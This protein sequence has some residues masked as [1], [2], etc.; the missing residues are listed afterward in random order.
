MI[1][2]LSVVCSDFVED[3]MS[4][5]MT[6]NWFLA[7]L[8]VLLNACANPYLSEETKS[9]G[10]LSND[11]VLLHASAG[12]LAVADGR[13]LT[14]NDAAFHSKLDMIQSA[15]TSVDAMYYIYSD[16]LSSS[17]LTQALIDAAVRGVRVRL[18]VD[19]ATTYNQL[20][21]FSMMEKY[22]NEGKGSL[23]VRLF[24]R[25][26]RAIVQD[27][28]Y[29]TL[30]CGEALPK[31]DQ[32]CGATKNQQIDRLFQGEQIGGKP[33]AD[34][35][36]S[37]L[38][39]GN[40]GLF[41]SGLYSKKPD[42]MALAVL[43]GQS[44]DLDSLKKSGQSP[45]A[46]ERAQLKK[47]AQIYAETH[48]KDPFKRLTSQIELAFIF[49]VYGQTL[50]PLRDALTGYLPVERSDNKEAARD[51]E[52]FTDYLHHKFLLADQRHVQLGGRN[53]EDSYHTQRNPLTKKY[54]FMD[55]DLRL[56]LKASEAALQRAFEAQWNFISMVAT[57]A[58]VR[59]H[60]PNDYAA[61][62]ALVTAAETACHAKQG[63]DHNACLQEKLADHMLTLDQRIEERH[64]TMQLHAAQYW[65]DYPFA[66][67]VDASPMF[68]VDEGAFVAYVENLPFYGNPGAPPVTR[69]YGAVN[70][71][72]ALYGKRIHSLW[73][74]GLQNVC[75]MAT[76]DN[77]QRVILHSAYFAPPSNLLRMLAHMTN[78]DMDCRHV[79]ITVLT[80]SFE[81]TDLGVVNLLAQQSLK[82]FQEYYANQRHKEKSPLIDYYEYLTE[83]KESCVRE[84][85]KPAEHASLHTKVSI[86]G[87]DIIVG[88]ANGD[89]RSYMMDSNN[90]MIIRNAP[91]LASQYRA[92]I[93]DL[94]KNTTKLQNRTAFFAS[95][96]HDQMVQDD[97]TE[98]EC[99]I[100]KYNLR[101]HLKPEDITAGQHDIVELL[102]EAYNLSRDIL[103]GGWKGKAAEEKYNRM[104][105]PI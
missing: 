100:Q 70:G 67:T 99:S 40:S 49:K 47:V 36:I 32:Q 45:S 5:R 91:R 42:L 6:P 97:L 10:R 12:P 89:V 63:A 101:K 75:A 37:N 4:T 41:L 55:T 102:N 62:Y 93:D 76:A 61:N 57:L 94:L 43:T 87:D 29:L 14:G 17:V 48:Q 68:P 96:S 16:D 58:E 33:A 83:T 24:Y 15:K 74:L 71:K 77:P 56:D 31:I 30:G 51:W 2:R 52:Y 78:G 81:T 35:G 39:I 64:R 18:L 3:L 53:V 69:S 7:L 26:S 82:A 27:A 85:D 73:L 54:I 22:G 21:L 9:T 79:R 46:Q 66:R 19:Y 92:Y 88:S 104:F 13:I 86:F 34:L 20:D 98:M 8:I 90:A 84:K 23:E 59:Q 25:P 60:A 11:T 38:N 65:T 80:N 1:H 95:K 50:D 103:A 44:I 72:E 28:V 105:K